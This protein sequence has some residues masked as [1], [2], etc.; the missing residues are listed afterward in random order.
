MFEFHMRFFIPYCRHTII[1]T[2]TLRCPSTSR[3]L[4][5]LEFFPSCFSSGHTDTWEMKRQTQ[6]EYNASS[7]HQ[8]CLV[9][10][11]SRV[12][13]SIHPAE[14]YEMWCTL[15][16]WNK[17]IIIFFVNGMENHISVLELQS[18]RSQKWMFIFYFE[19]RHQRDRQNK[20]RIT[21]F[22]IESHTP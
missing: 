12:A 13:W 9:V 19:L 16:E 7:I 18:Q 20:N 8:P 6:M 22:H 4:S 2:E 15:R 21:G 1:N 11:H 5:W 14:V 17:R 3:H 10:V